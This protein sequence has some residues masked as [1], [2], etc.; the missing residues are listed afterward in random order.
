MA[1][2]HVVWEVVRWSIFRDL[3]PSP[4]HCPP[5]QSA[6][7]PTVDLARG[8]HSTTTG[9]SG[10]T[11]SR[12]DPPPNYLSITC[13]RGEGGAAGRLGNCG[14][15]RGGGWGRSP[16]YP[17]QKGQL[18]TGGVLSHVFWGQKNLSKPC[19]WTL[20]RVIKIFL[21]ALRPM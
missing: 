12:C 14:L 7:W 15:W 11:P 19:D 3:P 18:D 13:G 5:V 21:A 6:P 17:S 2:P 8:D 9:G 20:F 4:S 10:R 16:T 1:E